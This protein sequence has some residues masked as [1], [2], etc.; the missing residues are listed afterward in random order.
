LIWIQGSA[1]ALLWLA[2]GYW[3]RGRFLTLRPRIDGLPRGIKV[4][5]STVGFL[6]SIAVL[7]AGIWAID[8]AGGLHRGAL[9]LWAL[10]I[11]AIV[12]LVFVH[13]QST[14]AA[15]LLSLVLSSETTEG[16]SASESQ[17][18]FRS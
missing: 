9:T 11:V 13:L 5:R 10:P 17:A 16:D 7:F 4:A 18:K 14:S 2:Y 6:A 3:L 8:I 15:L 12:G 1:C